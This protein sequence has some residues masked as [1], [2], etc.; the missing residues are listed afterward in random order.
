MSC[1]SG[2]CVL[3]RILGGGRNLFEFGDLE[4]SIFATACEFV[5]LFFVYVINVLF[6]ISTYVISQELLRWL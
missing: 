6:F 3:K 2:L 4:D 1:Q 5:D